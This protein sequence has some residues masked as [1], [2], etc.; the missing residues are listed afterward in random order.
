MQ[1]WLCVRRR[2]LRLA[3][4]MKMALIGLCFL[5]LTLSLGVYG[6]T[7]SRS[8]LKHTGALNAAQLEA[9]GETIA[10]SDYQE[11]LS[12]I[13]GNHTPYKPFSISADKAIE[14]IDSLSAEQKKKAVF[15]FY[16]LTPHEWSYLPASTSFP[17]G[18]AVKDLE[19]KQK[20]RLYDLMKAYLSSAGYEKTRTIMD[21][22]HVL[23][24]LN[25]A[26]PSRIPE[27]YFIAI[28]GAPSKEGT[29]GWSFQGHH[30]VLNFT[31]VKDNVA[32]APF[33][34]GSNPAEI[35][36]GPRKGTRPLAVEQDVAF[37]L[38]SS[39]SPAQKQKAIF[40]TDSFVEIVTGSS[41]QVAPLPQVG[42]AAKDLSTDQKTILKRL[43]SSILSSMPE[44]LATT[45]LAKIQGEG[46]GSIH[47]GWAGRAIKTEPHYYRIQGKSFLVEFDN[48]NGNHIHLVWRDFEG[49][50]GGD[51]L[52][53][54]YKTSPHHK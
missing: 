9:R 49:D 15:P 51:L 44:N 25:P 42:I 5:L 7:V 17:G 38:M 29:W 27:N 52:R 3:E 12:L 30:V 10:S 26:N 50:F 54:H 43:L 14:F 34:F 8:D 46:L 6:H 39:F 19:A 32:F 22:E 20:D 11:F 28:Y 13:S 36:T 18:I 21:L 24:E 40:Q 2:A 47:F 41:T 4:N 37:E 48:L 31:V 45:R 33:F 23:R 16:G 35:T 1:D 53:E